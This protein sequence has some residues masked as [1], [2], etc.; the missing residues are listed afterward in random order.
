MSALLPSV[1]GGDRNRRS[2]TTAPT[3]TLE[4]SISNVTILPLPHRMIW[5]QI[6]AFPVGFELNPRRRDAAE[7][8]APC[9]G[10]GLRTLSRRTQ[11]TRRSTCSSTWSLTVTRNGDR[12]GG[13]LMGVALICGEASARP[14]MV[15][16]D[17]GTGSWPPFTII[18]PLRRCG[19]ARSARPCCR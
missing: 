13:R 10:Q 17:P 11:V 15:E 14:L 16:G 1:P 3:W 7:S 4:M 18:M 12:A 9:C 2:L 6:S 8:P 19:S 5:M